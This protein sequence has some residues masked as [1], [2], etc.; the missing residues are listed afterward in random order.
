MGA[1]IDSGCC[2]KQPARPTTIDAKRPSSSPLARNCLRFSPAVDP[3]FHDRTTEQNQRIKKK[4][5]QNNTVESDTST[6]IPHRLLHSSPG[7]R[8]RWGK[9]NKT[10]L[11]IWLEQDQEH[12]R[13]SKEG[14]SQYRWSNGQRPLG[15]ST[16]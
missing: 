5:K 4:K 12:R 16:P 15:S 7:A 9:A 2:M 11:Q 6:A 14:L 8:A 10:K 3:D 1:S 13:R